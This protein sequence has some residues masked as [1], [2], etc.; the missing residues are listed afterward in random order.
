MQESHVMASKKFLI[1]SF[2]LLMVTASLAHTSNVKANHQK[3]ATEIQLEEVNRKLRE[4]N[5]ILQK[6]VELLQQQ[7]DVDSDIAEIREILKSY[8][9]DITTLRINQVYNLFLWQ[10]VFLKLLSL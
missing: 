3:E 4:E 9:E 5:A 2:F 6:Q 1:L 10:A 8:G 7:R